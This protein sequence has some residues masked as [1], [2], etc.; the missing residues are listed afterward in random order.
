MDNTC[1]R[2]GSEKVIPGLPLL[3]NV[4]T[5]AG[6][7]WGRADV[8][9]DTAPDAWFFKGPVAAG[10]SVNVCGGCGHAE[11]NASNFSRLYE[12]YEKTS[13]PTQPS[14]PRQAR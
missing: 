14:D 3:V 2:C 9:I 8:A 10:L 11:L 5:A 13:P 1:S 12:A 6:S 4:T 7:G